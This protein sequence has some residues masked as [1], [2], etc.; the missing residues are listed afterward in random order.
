MFQAQF[1]AELPAD[2]TAAAR[3]QGQNK[4]LDGVVKEIVRPGEQ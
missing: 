2:I 3:M 1:E 4:I